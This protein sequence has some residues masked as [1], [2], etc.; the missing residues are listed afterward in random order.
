MN[1]S[2]LTR[3]A[4]LLALGTLVT[5]TFAAGEKTV[6]PDLIKALQSQEPRARIK[7]VN[8]LSRFGAEAVPVLVGSLKD[9]DPEVFQAASFALRLLRDDDRPVVAALKP[10][11]KDE[12]PNVR[13]AVV[14]AL[15][16]RG[17]EGAPLLAPAVDDA[18]PAVRREAVRSIEEVLQREPAAGPDLLPALARA[19][20]DKET[21]IRL[22]A[23]EAL[24]RCG[25]AAVPALLGALKDEDGSVRCFAVEGLGSVKP[26]A[27]D[28]LPGVVGL[29]KDDSVAVR[30]SAV[31][32]LGTLGKP[33]VEPLV[34]ALKD[35]DSRV[36]SGALQALGHLGADARTA[37]PALKEFAT[38]TEKATVR[39]QALEALARITADG[40][41]LY[42]EM[43]RATDSFVRR[44][45]L[46]HLSRE[47]KVNKTAVPALVT[48]LEDKE[49]A[50]RSLAAQ[51]LAK[52][53]PDARDAVEALT[54]AAKDSDPHVQS[55]AERALAKVRGK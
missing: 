17:R 54:K 32:T 48:A 20:K 21:A 43:L 22:M 36:Q 19:T 15:A 34:T 6:P 46:L 29:L 39:A 37:V 47:R 25:K 40:P 14:G 12:E 30:G 23:V 41:A 7:A 13:R 50:V 33:A 45:C 26:P 53:G 1:T 31:R 27:Q 16:R 18:E 8:R 52:I 10:F 3:F 5:G 28:V 55:S 44:E 49:P 11:L 4:G 35:K 51:V 24:P 42:E 38:G 2:R 9:P